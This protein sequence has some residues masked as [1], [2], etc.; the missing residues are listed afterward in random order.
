MTCKYGIHEMQSKLPNLVIAGVNKAGTTSL[1]TYLGMHPKIHTSL[2]KEACY[3]LPIRYGEKV[4]PIA[5]YQSLFQHAKSCPVIMEATPGYFYGGLPLIK[6]IESTLTD[7][8][9]IIILRDPA[10]RL[11]S[12][13]RFM[14]SMLF[15]DRQVNLGNYIE[16]CRSLSEDELRNRCN[17]PYFGVEG[18]YYHKYIGDWVEQFNDRLKV[19]FFEDI[20]ENPGIVLSELCEWLE[21]DPTFYDEF[22]FGI[23][24]RTAFYKNRS[25]HHIAIIVNR[26]FEALFRQY[27]VMKNQLKRIYALFNLEVRKDITKEEI[28]M[29]RMLYQES[30]QMLADMMRKYNI[31]RLPGWL[32][33]K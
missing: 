7:V 26:K 19:L 6:K 10:D 22:E 2:I 29:A 18:G 15:V 21:I 9:I 25:L 31:V 11:V 23:E 5:E 30:N 28:E 8:K 16:H 14:K 33:S 32:K 4:A 27:P 3:F 13:F 17:N 1:F 12:F 24:N 20:K